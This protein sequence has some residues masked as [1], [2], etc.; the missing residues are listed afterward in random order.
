MN[1][2]EERKV[3][4]YRGHSII[5]ENREILNVSGVEHVSSFNDET[6]ILETVAGVLTIKGGGLDVNK[7]NI[8]DGN[9]SISGTVYSLNY[10]NKQGAGGG[11][12]GLLGRMFK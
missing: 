11:K 3:N 4:G 10:S 2:L 5:L 8:E 12:S 1:A 7:L 6:V 9:I